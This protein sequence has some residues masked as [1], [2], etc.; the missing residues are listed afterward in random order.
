M[1][2]ITLLTDFGTRDEYVGAMKGVMLSVNPAAKLVDISHH[3]PAY[4]VRQ[5][6][7]LLTA[8]YPYF[9]AGTVH[10]VVVDPGVGGRRSA[11]ALS[12]GRHFF[13]GPDNGVFSALLGGGL[14]VDI[15]R[16]ENTALF[17]MPVSRTF[18][19]RDIFAPVA[20]HL[21]TGLALSRLGPPL[22]REEAVCLP[23]PAAHID[24]DGLLAG[25]VIAVDH[26]GNLITN[27]SGVQVNDLLGRTPGAAAIVEAGGHRIHGLSESYQQADGLQPLAIIGSR[28]TVEIAVNRRSA[29]HRL[30]LAVGDTVRVAALAPSAGKGAQR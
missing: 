28:G 27:I 18:H 16:I 29:C 17:H 12:C 15:V 26:F 11:I 14:S 13:V 8:A 21:S 30:A 24:N 6:A 9:P 22:A 1:D 3:V 5:T 19:G 20:A 25:E 23:M 7:A 2:V 4:D 10:L